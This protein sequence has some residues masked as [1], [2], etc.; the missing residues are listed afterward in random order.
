MNLK[1]FIKQQVKG[2]KVATI[3]NLLGGRRPLFQLEISSKKIVL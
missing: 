2:I 1:S 3:K